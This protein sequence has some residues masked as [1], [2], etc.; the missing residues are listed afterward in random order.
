MYQLLAVSDSLI[1]QLRISLETEMG[2][3]FSA[4]EECQKKEKEIEKLQRAKQAI[5][6]K[7]LALTQQGE[8]DS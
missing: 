3:V 2:N 1:D 4:K 6:E 5:S 8:I 7:L